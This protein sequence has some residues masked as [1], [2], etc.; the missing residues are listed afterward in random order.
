MRIQVL[1]NDHLPAFGA[2]HCPPPGEHPDV[3]LILLN[4][5]AC[6]GGFADEDGNEVPMD[7]ADKKRLMIET[8]MHEFGHAL[9]H[10]FGLGDDETAIEAAI[11]SWTP[12][13]IRYVES[14]PTDQSATG[15]SAEGNHAG[16]ESGKQST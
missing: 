13:R 3:G 1:R 2:F 12:S 5:E 7:S 16:N 15:A 8:L 4:V 14:N 6:L 11:A 9:E 10:H